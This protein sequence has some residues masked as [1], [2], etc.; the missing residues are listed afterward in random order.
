MTINTVQVQPHLV[1]VDEYEQMIRT[2]AE[3]L[4]ISA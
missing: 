3:I 2:V 1:T 4:G